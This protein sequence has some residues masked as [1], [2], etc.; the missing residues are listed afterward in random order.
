MWQGIKLRYPEYCVKER[1]QI[2]DEEGQ[3]VQENISSEF[4]AENYVKIYERE[5]QGK[6]YRVNPMPDIVLDVSGMVLWLEKCISTNLN[7]VRKLC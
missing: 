4:L 3:A 1:L 6:S 5:N 7:A 2:T